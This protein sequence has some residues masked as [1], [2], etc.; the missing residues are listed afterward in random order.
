MSFQHQELALG[1]WGELSL[2]EQMAN[3]GSE[4]ERAL[5][6]RS[7]NNAEYCNGAFDRALEL[8]DMTLD[9]CNKKAHLKEVART[10]EVLVD[11]FFGSNYFASSVDS[12]RSYF[13]Q[14]AYAARKNK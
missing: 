2:V 5:K 10:R 1:R 4:V 13:L 3:V 9:N 7:K 14:F 11:F 8:L 12:L 6:W